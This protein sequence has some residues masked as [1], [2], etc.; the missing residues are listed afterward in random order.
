MNQDVICEWERTTICKMYYL[1]GHDFLNVYPV[2]IFLNS[3][4]RGNDIYP[5]KTN[6]TTLSKQFQNPIEKL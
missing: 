5:N 4:G 6:N 3:Q 2:C 1:I